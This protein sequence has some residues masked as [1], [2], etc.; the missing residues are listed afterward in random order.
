MIIRWV[1]AVGTFALNNLT[2]LNEPKCHMQVSDAD[3]N[4]F[5]KFDEIW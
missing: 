4:K 2:S 3:F 5:C 1:G